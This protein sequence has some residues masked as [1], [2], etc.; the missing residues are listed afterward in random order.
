M[1][2]PAVAGMFYPNNPQALEKTIGNYLITAESLDVK[3][4]IVPH[5]GYIFSGSVAGSVF[6][7]LP[8]VDT[9]IIIGPNHSFPSISVSDETWRTPLGEVAVNTDIVN[10]LS[11]EVNNNAHKMEHSVEVQIPF[12]QYKFDNFD[13]VPICM[14]LQGMDAIREVSSAL[15]SVAS[16]NM[17]VIASSDFTHYEPDSVARDIDKRAIEPIKTLNVAEFLER[18]KGTSICG[19]GP[20]AVALEYAK[21]KGASQ[22]ELLKYATSGDTSGDRRAVVGY[23]GIV[24]I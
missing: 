11:L 14:G 19:F 2:E 15:K 3:S 7:V 4:A 6:S 16:E 12:L 10:K 24:V 13:I 18:A 8:E 9:Y 17:I 1:R 23:A 20:I 5:A 21:F 22:G